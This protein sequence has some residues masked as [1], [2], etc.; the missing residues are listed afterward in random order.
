MFGIGPAEFI[1]IFSL[2][3][4][5]LLIPSGITG[6]VLAGVRGRNKIG[7][8]L[9]CVICPLFIVLIIC[10]GDNKKTLFA[11]TTENN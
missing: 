5:F 1:I 2:L 7:W 4:L 6:A 11:V 3:A 10:L 9:L 8:F